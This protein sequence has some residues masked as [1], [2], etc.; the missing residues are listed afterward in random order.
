MDFLRNKNLIKLV[1]HFEKA[2]YQIRVVGGAVRDALQNLPCKDIDLCTDADPNEMMELAGKFSLHVIPT[3]LQHGTVT[4]VINHEPFE[5]TTLRID[6]ETDGRHAQ[7]EYTRDFRKDAERRDLTINAMSMDMDGK[8]YDYFGGAD[9]LKKNRIKFVGSVEDRI[10]EDYLRVLR[11]FRFAAKMPKW[12]EFN[13]IRHELTV[14]AYGDTFRGLKGISGERIWMELKKIIQTKHANEALMWLRNSRLLPMISTDEKFFPLNYPSN[15]NNMIDALN[16]ANEAFGDNFEGMKEALVMGVLASLVSSKNAQGVVDRLKFSVRERKYFEFM[17]RWIEYIDNSGLDLDELTAW[18]YIRV[19]E[20]TDPQLLFAAVAYHHAY[21]R[22]D[23]SGYQILEDLMNA[24]GS[25]KYA[26]QRK[27]F[28]ITGKDL[29]ER[30]V[31][32]GPAIGNM[33]RAMR[34][35][36][37]STPDI[38]QKDRNEVM[39]TILGGFTDLSTVYSMRMVTLAADEFF[40]DPTGAGF[41]E[42]ERRAEGRRFAKQKLSSE[43]EEFR[44]MLSEVDPMQDQE[45]IMFFKN[46]DEA[47]MAKLKEDFIGATR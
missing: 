2:G 26:H 38:A 13:S 22:A 7:V 32:P 30:G 37:A 39:D 36:W 24:D 3:G 34:V 29:M 15:I 4:F 20:G 12:P 8:L 6:V 47:M 42:E 14:F 9:D 43:F 44:F 17:T 5:V 28:D 45:V 11:W 40:S 10:A 19:A 1:G 21:Y 31:K 23:Q 27:P 16:A 46:K 35:Y 33:L 18:F 25:V 41:K